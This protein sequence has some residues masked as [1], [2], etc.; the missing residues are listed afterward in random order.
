MTSA[1]NHPPA[2]T[3]PES[4][5][6]I[7]VQP[8]AASGSLALVLTAIA[9]VGSLLV[10]VSG[11]LALLTDWLVGWH[12][13]RPWLQVSATFGGVLLLVGAA[14][15]PTLARARRLVMSVG[16]LL[17]LLAVA[18]SVDGKQDFLPLI[19]VL[20]TTWALSYADTTAQLLQTGRPT[21]PR[22]WFALSLGI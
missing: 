21:T 18:D 13:T 8:P 4:A 14:I 10:L 16:G 22:R 17:L 2:S 19:T 7:P 11:A 15:L 12:L 20:L 6:S 1:D 5:H 9:G 3:P